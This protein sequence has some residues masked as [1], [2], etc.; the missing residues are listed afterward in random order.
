MGLAPEERTDPEY[1][2]PACYCPVF[3]QN[4]L[5]DDTCFFALPPPHM[6]CSKICKTVSLTLW[7]RRYT[8]YSRW[9]LWPWDVVDRGFAMPFVQDIL[10]HRNSTHCQCHLLEVHPGAGLL[11]G[12]SRKA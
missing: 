4:A 12:T 9:I 8:V 1:P 7:G 2:V 10:G 3:L 5:L 11:C 6:T